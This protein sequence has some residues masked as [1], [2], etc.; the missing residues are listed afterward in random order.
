MPKT[1]MSKTMATAHR[2]LARAL[3]SA[4]VRSVGLRGV[5]LRSIGLR[6][7]GPP[8]VALLAVA[9]PSWAASYYPVR[10]DDPKAIY[11]A[12]P[13]YPVRADGVAD[14]T[15]AIQ[16]A[17]DQAA[18]S[19]ERRIVFIPAGRYRLT[20]PIY[21]WPG[22][23]VIGYGATRPV[24]VLGARTPGYQE[25]ENF[26]VFFAGR[27]PDASRG[28]ALPPLEP[29]ISGRGGL[30]VAYPLDA[31]PGTFYSAI[32]NI[33]IEIQEGN[34][35]AVGIRAR[36]AQHA[37]MAHMD[38][39]L[40]D[41]MAGI[42]DG[43]NF[44]EDIHFH[45]GQFGIVTR[46]PSPGWQY[47]LVDV[48]FEGQRQAAIRT[49]EAGLTLIHPR[50]SNVP[51][52]ILTDPGFVEELWIKDGRMEDI[53]GP[54]VIISREHSLRNEI[55]MEDIVCR[56]VPTFARF[57]ESGRTIG[58]PSSRTAAGATGGAS[59]TYAVKTFS[60]GLSYDDLGDTGAVRTTFDA[61]PIAQLPADRADLP[62]LP[63]RETWVNVHTLG[64]VGDGR[65]DDTAAIRQALA[66]HRTLYFPIG[67]YVVSDTIALRPDTVIVALQPNVTS[68]V[69]QDNTPAFQGVGGPVPVLEAPSGGTTI[70]SGI[71][72][73]TNGINP[74]ALAMKWMAGEQSMVNDVRF[75]GG[76]GTSKI[77]GSREEIYNNTHT[78]DPVLA[79]RWDGQYPSLWITNGGGGTFADLWTPSTFAQAGIYV[80][81]T[82]TRGRVYAVSSE[83]HVRSEMVLRRVSNWAIYALQT[84]EER[85]EG[86]FALPLE[87]EQ[88][89]DIT[90]A[91]LH[92]Y[93]VVSAFQPF[94]YAIR[95]SDSTNIRFRNVHCYSDSKVSFD[96]AV[97]DATHDVSLRQREFAS[98]T[99][100]GKPPRR[101][102]SRRPPTVPANAAL[103]KLA[104]GF[105]N[106]S[107][108]AISPAGDPFFVDSHW[109][110]IYRWS[111]QAEKLSTVRDA[112]L[113]AANLVFDKAGNLMVVSYAGAGTVYTFKPDTRAGA[114]AGANVGTGRGTGADNS[115][116]ASSGME[117]ALL[118]PEPAADRPGMTAA[119]PVGH[120]RFDNNLPGALAQPRPHHFVSPDRTTFIPADDDFIRGTLYY[121][122]KIHDVLRAFALAKPGPGG[123]FYVSDESE[124]Q[125]FSA[126]ADARGQLTDVQL[127]AEQGGEGL[128]V[129]A[130]GN[131]Y[132]AAG[133]IHVYNPAGQSIGTID[134]PERPTG[135]AF[136]GADG[137]TLF[138]AAR[139][140]LYA[141]RTTAAPE[142]ATGSK[143]PGAATTP[144]SRR[145]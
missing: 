35:R 141:I 45:G 142:A 48:T 130:G 114:G 79:R 66:A 75:H 123:R 8:A 119:L 15:A 93:R 90:V 116:N 122:S 69:L 131:V 72:I 26:M 6:R 59:T 62:A 65:T 92:M 64:V 51:T 7:A 86:G 4:G 127:F 18:A 54:A 111:A 82:S 143:T 25:A 101:T 29:R 100:S 103:R 41:A 128:A 39:H 134:V 56:N 3:G 139:S 77:D 33:D 40:G 104:S 23:R 133:Q 68:F 44:A 83:H 121:G 34:P 73:Y 31:N 89:S 49:H 118:K 11:L 145:R 53:S 50:F 126:T 74:R 117:I 20:K 106:L 138:I 63:P 78:A 67:K 61:A 42:H 2:L 12:A 32:A 14:D 13:D 108:L 87:I 91:N 144:S 96:N 125:T 60:H 115:A 102:P 140:S 52:A 46:K 55:N 17:I 28:E 9:S 43:G 57:R 38:F 107:G 24:L 137:R 76:H 132:L 85:G 109:Q 36:Y 113:D 124:L 47:V 70:V 129:D 94:P 112:P 19:V 110:M 135:L 27:R 80:S 58:A 136:G 95:V 98:L 21:I 105:Y 97:Y 84:E 81:D 10:L 71:G 37:Y 22:V 1:V 30:N 99:I 88:S 120:W 16:Q 5:G